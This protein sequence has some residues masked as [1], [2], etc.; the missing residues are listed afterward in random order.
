MSHTS[1]IHLW[2]ED[3]TDLGYAEH[4]ILD[5]GDVVIHVTIGEQKHDIAIGGG[6]RLSRVGHRKSYEYTLVGASLPKE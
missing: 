1:I 5:N 3:G 6:V 2:M 4:E